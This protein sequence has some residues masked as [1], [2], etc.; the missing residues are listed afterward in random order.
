MNTLM[1]ALLTSLLLL[2]KVEIVSSFRYYNNSEHD[3]H[4]PVNVTTGIVV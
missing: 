4:F 1:V 3:I 2:K